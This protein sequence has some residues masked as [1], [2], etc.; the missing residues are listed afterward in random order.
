MLRDAESI[1]QPLER[2]AGQQ[3]VKYLT[4]SPGEVH[5]PPRLC[6]QPEDRP[7]LVTRP[8]ASRI[9]VHGLPV[10]RDIYECGGY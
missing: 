1:W 2:V 8:L 9:P 5:Q 6:E 4:T 7:L 10:P 3:Q